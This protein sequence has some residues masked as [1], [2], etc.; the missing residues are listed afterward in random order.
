MLKLPEIQ[1]LIIMKNITTRCSCSQGQSYFT[2]ETRGTQ[3]GPP[4][5]S[6]QE[7]PSSAP[8]PLPGTPKKPSWSHRLILSKKRNSQVSQ[9]FREDILDIFLI[10]D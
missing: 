10:Q 6:Y 1:M 9:N 8:F 3:H 4:N 7:G 2:V 5:S